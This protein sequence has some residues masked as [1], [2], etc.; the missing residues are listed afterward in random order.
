[1]S[2]PLP[3]RPPE[4]PTGA[5]PNAGAVPRL[6]PLNMFILSAWFGLL[7]GLLEVGVR[8]IP[9]GVDSTNRLY[10]MSRHFLW[11]VPLANLLVFTGVGII[12]AW[13]SKLWPRRAAWFCPRLVCFLA[14]L[15]LLLVAGPQIYGYAWALVACGVAFLI[16]PFLEQRSVHVSRLLV[17]SFPALLGS[18][19]LLGGIVFGS[20]FLKRW[21]EASRPM[22]A[23]GSPNVIL[24]VLDTVRADRL[25]LYGYERPTSPT[26]ERLAKRGIR[27]DEARATAPW[28][29]PSHASIFT[30]RLPHE[31]GVKWTTPLSHDFP[32][33][34]G[35]LG[36]HG[37]ATAGFVA[38]TLLCSYDTGLDRGFTHYEDYVLEPLSPF[39]LLHLGGLILNAI[40]DL[41]R[42][43]RAT[44]DLGPLLPPFGSPFWRILARD[45]KKDASS[46]NHEFLQWLSQS[47]ERPRP[48]FV[49]LN[50]YDAHTPY[51]LPAGAEYRFGLKPRTEADADVFNLW[52]ELDKLKLPRHYQTLAQ[53]CYDSC[54][55]YLDEHL[56]KL[57]GEL[58]RRGVLDRTVVVITADHGEGLG[59]HGLFFHG[60]SLYRTEIGVPLLIVLP[61][62]SQPLVVSDV[63]SLSDLPAT[64]VDLAHLGAGSP[65]PG[66]SLA[67]FWRAPA[68]GSARVSGGGAISELAAPNPLDP[69][70][71]RSPAHRGPM[72]SLAAGEFAYIR[73]EGDGDEQLFNERVDPREAD[74]RVR[75]PATKSVLAR[76]QACLD[77]LRAKP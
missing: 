29:L 25:S 69:N 2:G 17:W 34:A 66:H 15:P 37:Y 8:V 47:A 5:V 55:A 13:A 33:L 11:L 41:A 31:L 45:R 56:G 64:I 67:R 43:V 30:G 19:L 36:S 24:V 40:P 32:T 42:I 52:V 72:V 9:R 58:E 14:V 57:F 27:F 28:T 16:V 68:P 48:F 23:D 46:V 26:L 1:V 60:E 10:G 77:Q 3:L 71:G 39:R 74:N 76:F 50:Y 44:I 38:N 73:N 51:L 53:D 6:S 62:H 65:F 61:S 54:I 59:E 18:V 75:S 35:Y 22:P 12:V 20:D 63:V 4:L 7:G 49:F 70:Q 21:R